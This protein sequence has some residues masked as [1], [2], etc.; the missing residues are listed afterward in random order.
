MNLWSSSGFSHSGLFHWEKF[1][2]PKT[3][4][5]FILE[6]WVLVSNSSTT[7]SQEPVCQTTTVKKR[8]NLLFHGLWSKPE[9]E[10][11]F[12]F[13]HFT[14]ELQWLSKTVIFVREQQAIQIISTAEANRVK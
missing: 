3:R 9:A 7:A 8:T 1:V 12:N 5:Q 4:L 10:V 2:A 11:F 6:Y 14:P 13:S